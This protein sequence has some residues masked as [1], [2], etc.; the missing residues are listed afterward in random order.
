MVLKIMKLAI[1]AD[2]V[3]TVGPMIDRFY[4]EVDA[5]VTGPDSLIIT[6][7]QFWTGTGADAT[8]LPDLIADNSY[9]NVYV[10]G[11]MQMEDLSTYTSGEDGVGQ[12][13]IAVPDGSNIRVDSPVVLE[14]VNYTTD[15][16]TTIET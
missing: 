5:D 15:S 9:F 4:Y 14:V 7:D 11:V 8:I 1:T 16:D 3:V 12:L 13:E 6:V 2:S 10:N